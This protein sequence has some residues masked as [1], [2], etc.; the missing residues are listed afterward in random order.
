MDKDGTRRELVKVILTR[1]LIPG[2]RDVMRRQGF[3]NLCLTGKIEETRARGRQRMNV[4]LQTHLFDCFGFSTG[5]RTMEFVSSYL[6]LGHL[7]RNK[8]DD[9]DDI[10]PGVRESLLAKRIMS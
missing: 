10:F 1:Q 2:T 6:H 9:D 4:F 8:L 5:S 7:I 3:E